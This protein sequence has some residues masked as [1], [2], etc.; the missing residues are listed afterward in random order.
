MAGVLCVAAMFPFAGADAQTV[1]LSRKVLGTQLERTFSERPF[2]YG[3]TDDGAL[4]EIFS[5][6]D[7][8]TWTLVI[9]LANG[10]S[11]VLA[12]GE[13]WTTLQARVTRELPV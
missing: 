13:S 3:V 10:Q 2:A 4:L 6:R 7:G 12:T 1:C 8:L 9:T 11:C 5:T